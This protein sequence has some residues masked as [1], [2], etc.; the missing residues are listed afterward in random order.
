MR[1]AVVSLAS[2]S[3]LVSRQ[4]RAFGTFPLFGTAAVNAYTQPHDSCVVD[5]VYTD[6][7]RRRV[8]GNVS[9][10]GCGPVYTDT[11]KCRGAT[12]ASRVASRSVAGGAKDFSFQISVSDASV[13]DER[14]SP[15]PRGRI[16]RRHA[17]QLAL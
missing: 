13:A 16:R 17:R 15:L 5:A 1:T 12:D 4:K 14:H 3:W 9:C 2:Q 8:Y 7:S 10:S 11:T 6:A